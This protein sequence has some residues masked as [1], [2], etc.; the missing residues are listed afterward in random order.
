MRL[1]PISRRLRQPYA[2]PWHMLERVAPYLLSSPM[3]ASIAQWN[4]LIREKLQT[5]NS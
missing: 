3:P 1:S 2:H 4:E 5:G